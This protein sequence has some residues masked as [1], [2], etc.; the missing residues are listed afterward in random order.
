MKDRL[1]KAKSGAAD[2]ESG[3]KTKVN[4]VSE[5]PYLSA[6]RTWNERVGSLVS[7]RQTWQF[8]GILSLL[9]ALTAV[10]GLI[11][12]GQQSR[13]IPFVV[14][15]DK[16]GQP[17]AAG[18][19][20]RARNVDPRIISYQLG[21][22]IRNARTVTT[23]T[24]IQRGLVMDLYSMVRVKDPA[25]AFLNEWLTKK[26]WESPF[27][28]A[29]EMTVE[30]EISSVLQRSNDT[31]QVNWVE[32]ERE[33]SGKHLRDPLQMEASLTVVVMPPSSQ[34][35]E[36]QMRRN[37]LGIYVKEMSWAQHLR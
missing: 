26:G 16:L 18:P 1:H 24:T 13:F 25:A 12:I 21:T 36:E 8:I 5:N 32:T 14:Q 35:D 2:E 9:I 20:T 22:F 4:P 11:Y 34:T 28:R 33:R 27:E 19:V 30:V 15:V 6:R 31:W 3:K 23:D 10:A 29:K 37:P 7:S 17:L